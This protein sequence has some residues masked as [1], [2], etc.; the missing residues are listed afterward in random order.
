MSSVKATCF[1]MLVLAAAQRT[2]TATTAC[3]N[4]TSVYCTTWIMNTGDEYSTAPFLDNVLTDVQAIEVDRDYLRILASGIPKF[5]TVI[6]NEIFEFL[7]SRPKASSDFE[8]GV[9]SV[10]VGDL[11][12]WGG[13]VGYTGKQGCA[14]GSSGYWPT[15]PSC[16]SD[17]NL[18]AYIPMQ[19]TFTESV[20]YQ[21]LGNIGLF[22]NGVAVYGLLDGTSYNSEGTWNSLAPKFEIYD[23]DING[24]HAQT[25]GQYHIH[26][27][28]NMMPALKGENN[29]DAKSSVWGF[30]ADGF[31]I[32]GPYISDG[33][34]AQ[35]CWKARNYY[36]DSLG[37]CGT[38][39]ERS[40]LL[41]DIFDLSQG[42]APTSLVGPNVQ[43]N[44]TT[45]SG[46]TISGESG[47]YLEDFYYDA[48]CTAQ[49]DEYL[50]EHNGRMDD[51]LG[52]LVF[53]YVFIF[54]AYISPNNEAIAVIQA[55]RVTGNLR[56]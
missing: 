36:N 56:I 49:G 13:D 8:D 22:S 16:P 53:K 27:T 5:T 42:T 12:E 47:I 2:T 55:F 37:G 4:E 43:D 28:T 1:A 46:N 20:C 33:V 52:Y 31:P 10:S 29:S 32:L 50:D 21:P 35:S 44:V 15:G 24:G 7:E 6:S 26:A 34:K 51:E 40:C 30:A 3:D 23:V 48:A 54:R 14:A 41:V 9:P 19:P 11:V 38:E 18:T 45:Q 25:S 39:G 17:Q